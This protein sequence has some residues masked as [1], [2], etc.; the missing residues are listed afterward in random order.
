MLKLLLVDDD[1]EPGWVISG[2]VL[3]VNAGVLAAEDHVVAASRI[4]RC[5]SPVWVE[6][7]EPIIRNVSG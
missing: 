3:D 2:K 4:G 1:V 7:P 5:A 6:G